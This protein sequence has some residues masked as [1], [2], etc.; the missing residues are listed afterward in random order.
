MDVAWPLSLFL[1]KMQPLNLASQIIF[2]WRPSSASENDVASE[3][4]SLFVPSKGW[5]GF[6]QPGLMVLPY[7]FE[8]ANVFS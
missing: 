6:P 7:T 3:G 8:N 4:G 2:R 5:A 1:F